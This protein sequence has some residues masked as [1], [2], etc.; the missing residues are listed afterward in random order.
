MLNVPIHKPHRQKNYCSSTGKSIGGETLKMDVLREVQT[1][2]Y[3]H[4]NAHHKQATMSILNVGKRN[5][6]QCSE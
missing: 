4:K 1:H 6:G 2:A 3:K 5:I